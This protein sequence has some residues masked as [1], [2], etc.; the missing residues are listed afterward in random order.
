MPPA[1]QVFR[2]IQLQ[3][4]VQVI[5]SCRRVHRQL[6]CQRDV[7]RVA[8]LAADAQRQ[9]VCLLVAEATPVAAA[10]EKAGQVAL[11]VLVVVARP[12]AQAAVQPEAFLEAEPAVELTDAGEEAHAPQVPG[13]NTAGAAH[14][15]GIGDV[16]V[17]DLLAG[18][19]AVDQLLPFA[20]QQARVVPV[21][22]AQ[23]AGMA[24]VGHALDHRQQGR[25][26]G[27]VPGLGQVDEFV[28]RVE[29]RQVVAGVV[30]GIDRHHRC[31][32]G[33]EP[34]SLQFIHGLRAI[35]P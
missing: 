4:P 29:V 14:Q 6:A 8:A 20:W 1:I 13:A 33:E 35:L 24:V 11:P 10:D 19:Q 23:I 32:Q 22:A 18:V 30:A 3:V 25:A 16:A 31:G 2:Q 27:D 12:Q 5:Q 26:I 21:G 15:D 9:L 7:R 17:G 34:A 28:V